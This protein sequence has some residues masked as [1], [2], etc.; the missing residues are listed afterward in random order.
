VRNTH[1]LSGALPLLSHISRLSILHRAFIYIVHF[2]R[3]KKQKNKTKPKKKNKIRE[4]NVRIYDN[5]FFFKIIRSVIIL[6]TLITSNLKSI[7]VKKK[8]KVLLKHKLLS[9]PI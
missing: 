5:L 7:I 2:E 4:K 6:L 8:K 1:Q 3:N 9:S